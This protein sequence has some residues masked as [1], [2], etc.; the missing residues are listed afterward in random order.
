MTQTRQ[1]ETV[2]VLLPDVQGDQ[3]KTV[4]EKIQK[5]FSNQKIENVTK[6]DWGIR[7]LAYPIKRNKSGRYFEFSYT[8]PTEAITGLEKNLGYEESVL[9]FLTIKQT[10]Q[11]PKNVQVEP[12]GFDF[13]EY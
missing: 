12:D 9:R 1:Y 10:K 6:K 11:S 8:A 3:L 5:I 13:I 2:C 7:R 4:E